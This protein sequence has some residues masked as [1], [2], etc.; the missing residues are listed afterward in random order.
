MKFNP[1]RPNSIASS[2][3]CQGR[4]E[5]MIIIEQSLFQTKNG[6]PQHFLVEGEHG[7]GKSSIFLVEEQQA[8]C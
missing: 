4:E 2:E 7:L 3:L 6:N 5:E 8:T 1:Y